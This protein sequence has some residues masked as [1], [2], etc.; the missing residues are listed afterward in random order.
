MAIVV[1]SLVGAGNQT[2]SANIAAT[3]G[4]TGVSANELVLVAIA[5][6]NSGT[7]GAS[8][9]SSVV[10]SKSNTYNQAFLQNRT[11]GSASNDGTPVALYVATATSALVNSDTVTV[12]FSPNVNAKAIRVLKTSGM[13]VT[14][15]SS[16]K[17]L[18]V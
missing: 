18:P 8:A 16:N 12:N 17:P 7:S 6:D 2:G 14:V 3:I 1:T 10:D 11:A 9:I 15:S 5:A 4:A 13:L